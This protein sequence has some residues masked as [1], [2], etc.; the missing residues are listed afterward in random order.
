[1]SAMNLATM[2][3]VVAAVLALWKGLLEAVRWLWRQRVRSTLKQELIHLNDLDRQFCV[4]VAKLDYHLAEGAGGGAWAIWPDTLAPHLYQL[5]DMIAELD[6]M[7]AHIRAQWAEGPMERLRDDIEQIVALMRRA[8]DLYENGAIKA[9]RSS[10]GASLGR[11]VTGSGPT[12]VIPDEEVRV[13]IDGLRHTAQVL[14]RSSAHQL[15]L[16][17]MAKREDTAVWPLSERETWALQGK[18]GYF[19]ESPSSS[20]NS[21]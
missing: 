18:F 20:D 2:V 17:D 7:R 15:G 13:E 11:S 19:Q 16:E 5:Q 12:V 21:P 8:T 10:G 4:T 14:F 3:G 6:D 9:Y 1:M